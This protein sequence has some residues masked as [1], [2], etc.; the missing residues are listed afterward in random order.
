MLLLDEI[1]QSG[2]TNAYEVVQRLRPQ[3]LRV[4]GQNRRSD[5]GVILVYRDTFPMGGVA[6]LRQISTTGIRTI[7]F[8]GPVEAASRLG[9]GHEHG[10]IVVVTQ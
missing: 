6:A 7:Q 10:A 8:L 9:A 3:W 5:R 1:Q 2:A 4:R